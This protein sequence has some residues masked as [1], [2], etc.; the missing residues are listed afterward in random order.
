MRERLGGVVLGLLLTMT[1]VTQAGAGVG[2]GLG[3]AAPAGGFA[4]AAGGGPELFVEY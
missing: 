1:T 4:D 2:F 3:Y